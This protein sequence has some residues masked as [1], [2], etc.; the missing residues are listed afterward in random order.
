[1]KSRPSLIVILSALVLLAVVAVALVGN[2]FTPH[3]VTNQDLLNR[4]KPPAFL[5]G[6][7]QYPLGTGW[8]PGCRC[9]FPWHWPAR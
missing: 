3:Q 7:E 2:V 4:L 9:R 1:M 5:G 6:P 8:S